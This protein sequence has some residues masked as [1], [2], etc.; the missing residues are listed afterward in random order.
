MHKTIHCLLATCLLS[1]PLVS[2]AYGNKNWLSAN[3][4]YSDSDKDNTYSWGYNYRMLGR[5]TTVQDRE[6]VTGWMHNG[7]VRSGSSAG[8]YHWKKF[9]DKPY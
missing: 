1:L 4:F 9:A 3:Q 7:N 6:D 2:Q 8:I 5:H